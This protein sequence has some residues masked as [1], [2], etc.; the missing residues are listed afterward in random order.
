MF[1]DREWMYKRIYSDL[2]Q[3][4]REGKFRPGD[5]IPSEKELSALYGVSRIT[6]KKAMTMLAEEGWI[7]RMP[8][9]GSFVQP[10]EQIEAETAPAGEVRAVGMQ[11]GSERRI[12]GV[13]LDSFGSDFGTGLLKSMEW[14]CRKRGYSILLRCTNGSIEE[15]NRAIHDAA[16]LGAC[17]MIIMCV[18]EETYNTTIIQL[19]LKNFPIVLVDRQMQGISIPCIKTDNYKAAFELTELL[20]KKNHKKIIFVS[21][22]SMKTSTVR[23]RYEG[24]ADCIMEHSEVKGHMAEI[25]GYNPVPQDEEE[26]FLQYDREELRSFL[27][28]NEEC[29]AF[30]VVE[31]KL[32]VLLRLVMKELGQEREIVT[33]DGLNRIYGETEFVHVKQDE[34]SMG[35]KAV[36]TIDD[37]ING[38]EVENV[39]CI[40]YVIAANK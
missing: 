29:D 38:K 20:V 8:G 32:G 1:D 26:E 14:E 17:G 10:A 18:H 15:E 23:E 5:R 30:L 35:I 3:G 7:T 40:P 22:S 16:A 11:P 21:H 37:I 28:A 12:L 6:S 27:L 39:V 13:I 24:F 25:V 36:E 31:Y 9:R 2:L 34:R 19:S 33:F 4:I